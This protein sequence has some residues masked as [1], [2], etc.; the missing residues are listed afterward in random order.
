MR[1]LIKPSLVLDP[2]RAS[3]RF[4]C[5]RLRGLWLQADSATNGTA[6]LA[7]FADSIWIINSRNT[8]GED[9]VRTLAALAGFT[10]HI[11]HQIDSLNLVED[12]ILDRHGVGLLPINRPLRDGLAVLTLS[13]PSVILTPQKAAAL[14]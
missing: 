8:A 1:I 12:L 7:A 2:I 6:D 10:P 13:D 5:G 4:R 3:N 14:S 11:A 9:A